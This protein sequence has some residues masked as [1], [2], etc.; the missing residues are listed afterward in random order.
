MSLKE[1][2]SFTLSAQVKSEL[3]SIVP[4][5]QRSQFIEQ[6]I[7]DALKDKHQKLLLGLIEEINPVSIDKDSADLIRQIRENGTHRIIP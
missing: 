2:T 6:A 1:R 4:K 3:E 7:V 5:S